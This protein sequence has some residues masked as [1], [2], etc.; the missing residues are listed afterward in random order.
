LEALTPGIT[1][2]G[3]HPGYAED[4][5]TMYAG[6]RAQE[7]A[8]LCDPRVREVLARLDIRLI[9]FTDVIGAFV[10]AAP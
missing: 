5:D 6:E 8:T 3:C 10:M 4:L 7:V 2:L 1:E 9:S